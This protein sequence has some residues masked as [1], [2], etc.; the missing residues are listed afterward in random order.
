V[1]DSCVITEGLDAPTPP[2]NVFFTS[3]ANKVLPQQRRKIV[4]CQCIIVCYWWRSGHLSWGMRYHLLRP[5]QGGKPPLLSV[6][7]R[8]I[9]GYR[10][11]LI[12]VYTIHRS[13][14]KQLSISKKIIC[15]CLKSPPAAV[16]P[17]NEDSQIRACAL[18][19]TTTSSFSSRIVRLVL[20]VVSATEVDTKCYGENGD[21]QDNYAEAPPLEFP[22]IPCRLDALV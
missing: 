2:A 5:V 15:A 4:E 7:I 8:I 17:S 13:C 20:F 21:D 1:F 19:Y 14:P 6:S 22:G 11:S 12:T 10:F 3:I 18:R 9:S 16:P